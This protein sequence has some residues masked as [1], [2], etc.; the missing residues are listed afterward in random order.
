MENNFMV[1]GL[2]S[3]SGQLGGQVALKKIFK[4]K[5]NLL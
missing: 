3:I 1:L 4:I 5:N 2:L